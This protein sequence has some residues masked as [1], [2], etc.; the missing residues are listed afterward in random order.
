MSLV[1][2]VEAKDGHGPYTTMENMQNWVRDLRRHT[3]LEGRPG[4]TFEVW[5]KNADEKF[6]RMKDRRFGFPTKAA[7]LKWFDDPQEIAALSQ[8]GYHVAVYQSDKVIR[9]VTKRQAVFDRPSTKER[10][11]YVTLKDF[12]SKPI[13][14]IVPTGTQPERGKAS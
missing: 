3:P 12:K 11:A 9:A 14:A 13:K 1:Y 10:L 8:I 7:L 2:R 4:P 6:Q 5:P